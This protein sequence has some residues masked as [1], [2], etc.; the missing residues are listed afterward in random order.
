ELA[1]F[2]KVIGLKLFERVRQKDV[3]TPQECSAGCATKGIETYR[4]QFFQNRKVQSTNKH[5]R[6]R[7]TP[8]HAHQLGTRASLPN[9]TS[10]A[11]IIFI[12]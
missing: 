2:E 7:E 9:F 6:K 3:N 4:A 10:L 5:I 11:A 8:V 1:R 12:P